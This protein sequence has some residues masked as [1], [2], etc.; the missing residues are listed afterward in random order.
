MPVAGMTLFVC[1]TH[2]RL[3]CHEGGIGSLLFNLCKVSVDG[4]K[5]EHH[6]GPLQV[7]NSM[8]HSNVEIPA[9]KISIL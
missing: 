4:R 5:K 6:L 7:K 8:W 2:P 3:F 1:L 9:V